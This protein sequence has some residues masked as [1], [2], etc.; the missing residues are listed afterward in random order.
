MEMYP[1]EMAQHNLLKKGFSVFVLSIV[2]S[3]TS[4]MDCLAQRNRKLLKYEP[5]KVTLVGRVVLKTFYGPP[6][7]GENPKTESK[8]SQYVLLLDSPVDVIGSLNDPGNVAE[9][10][11]RKV[12]LLVLDFKSHPVEPWRGRRVAVEGSLFHANTGHHHTKVLI[13][14]ASIRKP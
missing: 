9:R 12:T 11:V 4:H 13:E 14:V 2:L 6:N 10:G 7:Y 5:E 8:E 1:T 3:V